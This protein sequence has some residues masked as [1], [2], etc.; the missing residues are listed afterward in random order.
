[1]VFALDPIIVHALMDILENT[2]KFRYVIVSELMTLLMFVL[3]L[4]HAS[5]KTLVFVRSIILEQTVNYICVSISYTMIVPFAQQTENV[6][7]QIFVFVEIKILEVKNVQVPC[8]KHEM[9]HCPL[10]KIQ[11]FAVAMEFVLL[12]I[13]IHAFVTQN[14]IRLIVMFHHVAIIVHF[15]T[16]VQHQICVNASTMNIRY[17]RLFRAMVTKLLIL[18]H[19][20]TMAFVLNRIDA[21]VCYNGAVLI[22]I[23]QC[24]LELKI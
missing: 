15:L 10:T 2:V 6:L 16:V 5:K 7:R 9:E 8:A 11:T 22:V 4:E 18:K 19:V 1:M 23:E 20:I 12:V 3:V 21:F 24:V 13:Q 17:V 14:G